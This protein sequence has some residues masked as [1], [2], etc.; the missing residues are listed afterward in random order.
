VQDGLEYDLKPRST[1]GA[2]SQPLSWT[3]TSHA[4]SPKPTSRWLALA[5]SW[6][7]S[8]R[9]DAGFRILEQQ[10]CKRSC[11]YGPIWPRHERNGRRAWL[12]FVRNS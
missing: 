10:N 8:T 2:D 11:F 5:R 7:G 6:R 9:M 4:P 12:G 3:T 1:T